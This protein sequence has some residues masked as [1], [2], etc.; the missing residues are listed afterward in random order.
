MAW[1]EQHGSRSFRGR[2][3]DASGQRH[4]AG[5]STSKR[6]AMRMAQAAEVRSRRGSRRDKNPGTITFGEYFQDHWLPNRVAEVATLAGYRSHFNTT[7]DAEFGTTS[8]EDISNTMVQRWIARLVELGVQPSTIR[9]HYRTLATVLGSRGGVSAVRDGLIEGSPCVGIDLPHAPTR[10]IEAYSVREVDTLV[11]HA[12]AWWQPLI[13][14]AVDSGLRWGELM[15]LQVRDFSSTYSHLV[16]RR[17]IIEVPASIDTSRFVQKNFPKGR[18]S[19]TVALSPEASSQIAGLVADRKLLASDRVFS[20]GRDGSVVRTNAWPQG[21][22][23]SRSVFRTTVWVPAHRASDLRQRRFHDLRATHITWLL[24][25]G[26]DVSAVMRRVGHTRLSTTQVYLAALPDADELAM[27]AL[28][29]VR[30][31]YRQAP[32]SSTQ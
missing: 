1:V 18:Q 24:S 5:T 4:T 28:V 9:A 2:Y 32:G 21:L 13:I 17:T 31:R 11:M 22:P 16:V 25:G 12:A 27:N 8:I 6:E 14:L 19:R 10:D 26:A 20:V 29:A 23:I 7:L 30:E 3:R 15:G